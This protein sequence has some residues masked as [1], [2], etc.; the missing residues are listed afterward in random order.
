MGS[1]FGSQPQQLTLSFEHA[2]HTRG[3]IISGLPGSPDAVLAYERNGGF[4]N[5]FTSVPGTGRDVSGDGFAD[6]FNMN[7]PLPPNEVP[8][9]PGPGYLLE[10][11]DDVAK[12][13]YL[14]E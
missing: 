6:T 9:S 12:T 3:T 13:L 11:V 10:F 14:G 5:D 4:P 7:E 2:F 1:L 8:T